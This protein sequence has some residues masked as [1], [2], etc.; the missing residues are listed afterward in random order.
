MRNNRSKTASNRTNVLVVT[1]D[2]EFEQTVR[3][4]FTAAA[5]IDHPSVCPVFDS[6]E[7]DGTPFIA[8]QYIEGESLARIVEQL[9]PAS[10]GNALRG[11]PRSRYNAIWRFSERH[12]GRS[13]RIPNRHSSD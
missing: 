9:A 6:G 2:V 13:L 3:A 11:V 5:Q 1:A 4:T 7:I 10:V 8:M 12:G